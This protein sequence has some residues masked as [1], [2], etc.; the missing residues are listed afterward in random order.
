MLYIVEI[1]VNPRTNMLDMKNITLVREYR[2][3]EEKVVAAKA[4]G[5][6]KPTA[7]AKKAPVQKTA[8][9]KS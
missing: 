5:K 4:A 3:D 7:G 9:K 1:P 6:K 2:E 8:G